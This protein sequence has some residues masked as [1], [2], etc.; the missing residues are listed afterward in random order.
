MV[1]QITMITAKEAEVADLALIENLEWESLLLQGLEIVAAHTLFTPA[2]KESRDI[3]KTIH[4]CI[5]EAKKCKTQHAVK[6]ITQLVSVSKYIK[7]RVQYKKHKGCKWPNLNASTAIVSQMGKGAYFA[8]Q[9]Q[10]HALYLKRHQHLP[11]SKSYTQSSYQMLL[12]NESVLHDVYIYL[13]AQSLSTVSLH[14][15]CLHVNCYCQDSN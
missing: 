7:L 4:S 6:A 14:A 8:C 9:I 15:L 1:M 12:N 3:I 2:G 10:H 11:P 13:T 5:K